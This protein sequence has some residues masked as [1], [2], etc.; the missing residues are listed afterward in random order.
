MWSFFTFGI[1]RAIKL[2]TFTHASAWEDKSRAAVK[3]CD[4]GACR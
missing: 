3:K 4:W 2:H 1:L